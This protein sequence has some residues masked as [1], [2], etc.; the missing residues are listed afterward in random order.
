[1]IP[2]K[3]QEDIFHQN[4]NLLIITFFPGN[5]GLV[6]VHKI[7]RQCSIYLQTNIILFA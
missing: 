5:Q 1:M 4:D 6:D 2:Y 3:L 7:D